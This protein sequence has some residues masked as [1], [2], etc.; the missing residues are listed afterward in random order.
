VPSEFVTAP[1]AGG[2]VAPPGSDLVL[3]EVLDPGGTDPPTYIAPLHI[4]TR[5]DEAWYVLEGELAFLL[6]G[7]EVRVPAGGGIVVPAGSEHT[8]WNPLPGQTRYLLV[9]T[10]TVHRLVEALHEPSRQGDL[11]ALFRAHDSVLIAW[12]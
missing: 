10:A 12:P 7:S 2:T 6:E 1:L 4:H 11:D 3:T 8:F 9:M 5:D